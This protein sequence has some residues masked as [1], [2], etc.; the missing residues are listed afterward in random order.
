MI[1]EL[2]DLALLQAKGN[3]IEQRRA[4]ST[5]YYAAFH[6]LCRLVAAQLVGDPSS[7]PALYEGVY[8]SLDHK[9]ADR[10]IRFA[11]TTATE[12]VRVAL[13]ELRERR[14][15]AD[16]RPGSYAVTQDHV[17][18]T[19]LRAKWV[20]DQLAALNDATARKL[21]ISLAVELK[22]R[23]AERQRS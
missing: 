14:A 4:I 19:I 23:S 13:H 21:A 17:I 5:A 6:A 12:E 18:E 15:D 3:A 11:A 9:L 10:Q 1:D 20:V 16:Y 22:A 2:L 7:D 8:R